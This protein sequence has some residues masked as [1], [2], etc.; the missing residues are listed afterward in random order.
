MPIRDAI[1]QAVPF[2]PSS[3]RDAPDTR[4][5][6]LLDAAR[7]REQEL[8]FA[9]VAAMLVDVT[10]T[11]HGLTLGLTEVNPIARA[12]IDT[13]GVFGLYAL[14]ALALAVGGCCRVVVQDR[15]GPVVPVGLGLP[16]L[17]A[18]AVNAAVIGYV[19]I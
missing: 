19:T 3:K 4:F 18:V 2:G 6:R 17:A 13:A 7:S 5:E 11:V 8:W 16:S 10:L 14:K 15:Y 12:A 9:V 1:R